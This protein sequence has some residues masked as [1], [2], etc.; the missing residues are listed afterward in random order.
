VDGIAAEAAADGRDNLRLHVGGQIVSWCEVIPLTLRYGAAT[1]RVDGL[2]DVW[3]EPEH[4]RQGH[5]RR[6]LSGAMASL[7]AGDAALSFLYGIEDLY[8]KF[9]YAT[10]G[11]DYGLSLREL[12]RPDG[13]PPGWTVRPFE[14]DDT[15]TVRALYDAAGQGAV[16]P[17]VRRPESW[18]WARLAARP[19]G[20]EC[21]V[22]VGP[23]GRVGGY[24][25]RGLGLNYVADA[26]RYVPNALVLG[27]VL[28]PT[29]PAAE[30]LVAACRRWGRTTA[31]DGRPVSTVSVGTLPD[32][33]VWRAAAF[34]NANRT[35]H[36][37]HCGGPMVRL[38]SA[39]R[40]FEQAAPELSA[41]AAGLDWRGVLALDLGRERV[42]LALGDGALRLVGPERAP[43]LAVALT[44]PTLARLALGGLPPEDVLERLDPPPAPLA[45]DLLGRL[46][47]QRKPYLC[48]ADRP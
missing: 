38:L 40:L 4:R 42:H 13:A 25:W 18:V 30:A 48:L 39:R 9:G 16:G 12:D 5:A 11:A 20:D 15:A 46:F 3:T 8:P 34:T 32:G 14:R 45:A 7:E 23:D 6:L 10:V 36:S 26:E 41:R 43:T 21:R 47:P 2:G 22:V 24:A 28:A 1:L 19:D 17:V 33:Q 37:W 35:S 27:E 44:G 29:R 31:R